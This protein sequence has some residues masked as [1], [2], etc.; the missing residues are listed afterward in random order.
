MKK[1]L[2]LFSALL[3]LIHISA[4]ERIFFSVSATGRLSSG[5]STSSLPIQ[6]NKSTDCIKLNSGIAVHAGSRGS[7]SF[8]VTCRTMNNEPNIQ[9]TLFPNPVTMLAK[10]ISSA[11]LRTEQYL[12]IS[13]LDM[14]G[15]MLFQIKKSPDQLLAGID[16]DVQRLP[17]GSYF[18][19]VDGQ[20]FH[21]IISFIKMN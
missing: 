10:L 17:A 11:L 8:I 2:F 9:L 5:W 4:Q 3:V 15:R 6:I 1:Q 20:V 12:F 19:R 7:Q 21:Q 13:V 14:Q 16:I 18:L